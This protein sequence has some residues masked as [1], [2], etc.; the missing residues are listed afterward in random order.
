MDIPPDQSVPVVDAAVATAA[1]VMLG[2]LAGAI[3]GSWEV[4]LEGGGQVSLSHAQVIAYLDSLVKPTQCG[5]A[6]A[7]PSNVA[8]LTCTPLGDS[9]RRRLDGRLGDLR[10]GVGVFAP[11]APLRGRGGGAVI[12]V[13]GA[14][15]VARLT[16]SQFEELIAAFVLDG[17][18]VMGFRDPLFHERESGIAI[19][20]EFGRIEQY[21]GPIPPAE[22]F[23][24][25]A[26]AP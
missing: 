2:G 13:R 17:P 14:G 16:L 22:P 3:P 24:T 18:Y 10:Q 4:L 5:V 19:V 11:L 21:E 25:E 12:A 9:Q 1:K 15:A 6:I 26:S 23:G 7:S 8:A 20:V